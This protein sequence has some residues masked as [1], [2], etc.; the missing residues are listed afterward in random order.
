VYE[1]GSAQRNGTVRVGDILLAIGQTSVQ[2]KT[3]EQLRP[4]MIGPRGSLVTLTFK[5]QVLGSGEF[6]E[7]TIELMCGNNLYFLQVKTQLA[8]SKLE[9]FKSNINEVK[10]EMVQDPCVSRL[11]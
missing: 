6:S 4:F 9:I 10:V 7:Y 5:R 8:E 1:G 2:G 11:V 3:L